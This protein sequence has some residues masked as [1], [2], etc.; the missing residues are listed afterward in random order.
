MLRNYWRIML[1][2]LWKNR[3]FSFINLLGLATGMAVCLL[4]VLYIQSELGY[5]GFHAN[6][7][8]IYRLQMQ[9]QY[10]GRSSHRAGIPR[11]IGEAVKA[12]FPGVLAVT[13]VGD[14]LGA[15]GEITID[16]KVFTKQHALIVDSNFFSTFS[17]EFVLGDATTALQRPGT[18]V[19]TE[20]AAIRY[21]GSPEK[22]IGKKMLVG[23]DPCIIAAVCKDWPE[24]TQMPFDALLTTAGM[25]WMK[26]PEYVYFGAATYLLLDK[27]AS[28]AALQ[29]KLP[30]VVD[31]YVAPVVPRLFGESWQQFLAEGNGYSYSLLPLK[32]VHLRSTVE[33]DLRPAGSIRNLIVL[34]CIAA[35]ILL[36][37]GVNF[38]NL[39][40]ALAVQRAREVGIRKTFG[41]RRTG[42][43]RQFLAESLFFAFISI[44]LALGLTAALTPLLSNI[45]GQDL[46]FSCFLQPLHLLLVL[47]FAFFIGIVAGLYP[48]FVLSGF[49]PIEVLKGQFKTSRRGIALRNGLVIFQFTISVILIICTI[50]VNRQMQYVLGDSLGFRQD[51]VIVVERLHNLDRQKG[52]TGPQS[53]FNEV[54]SL[55]GVTGV[56]KCSDLPAYDEEG[57]GSTF[58][59]L[60]NRTSRTDRLI[61]GDENY[62]RLLNLQ[63]LQGRFF[64]KTMAT[65]SVGVVLNEAAV[66]DFGFKDPIGQRLVSKEP[67]YDSTDGKTKNI[68]TVIGVI[69]DFHY[70]SLRKKIAPL[71]ILNAN[72]FGYGM[73]AVRINSEH[74]GSTLAA[75]GNNWRRMDAKDDFRYNFLDR[76]VAALYKSE[77]TQQQIFTIFSSL[78]I[79][80]ACVGLL[81]LATYSVRQRMKEISIRKVLGAVPGNIVLILSKDFLVLIGAASLI[82]FPVAWLAMH[83]W[84]QNFAYRVEISWWIF[85]LAGALA[86]VIA[87]VTISYQAVRAAVSNPIDSLKSE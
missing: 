51:H 47:A 2:Q 23:Y 26:K 79:L 1:R 73:L 36:L 17:G 57:G 29:A 16:E 6:G 41:S 19:L 7:D 18:A 9:R 38:V 40:T 62:A 66:K 54:A 49:D 52:H 35:F 80:I 70:Q 44:L 68:F 30:Q 14:L 74:F 34:A 42:L 82:A 59:T 32:D 15:D 4:L 81:G 83:A 12:E 50:V 24:K 55:S 76:Q 85:V 39:S 69:K 72:K 21:F 28:P 31:K 61:L 8:R 22:A 3:T 87:M 5:D 20:S 13:H 25:E 86:A 37:A 75:I 84:L 67:Y 33:D 78:A 43:I 60:D 63:L 10:P 45:A 77:K 71:M 64:D 56:S 65:D 58:A 48:A 53:F 46:N 11:S 27:N